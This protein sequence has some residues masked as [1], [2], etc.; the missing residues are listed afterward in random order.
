MKIRRFVS[1]IIALI[2][3]AMS[4]TGAFASSAPSFT[5][6]TS[7]VR[8]GYVTKFYINHH[9]THS[10]IKTSKKLK[11]KIVKESKLTRKILTYR[12]NNYILIV[13]VNGRCIDNNGN[14][15]TACGSYINYQDCENAV[16][17]QRYITYCIYGNNNSIDD[18]TNRIDTWK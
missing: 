14:G 5:Y 7:K 12:K 15:K 8:K 1:L 16:K 3:F 4:T 6:K 17:G 2:I 11:I 9:Y 13:K 18:I 10:S